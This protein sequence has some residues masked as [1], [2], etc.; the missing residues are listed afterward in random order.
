MTFCKLSKSYWLNDCYPPTLAAYPQFFSPPA[1]ILIAHNIMA[2][3]SGFS[4]CDALTTYVQ[5]NRSTPLCYTRDKIIDMPGVPLSNRHNEIFII[6]ESVITTL[7]FVLGKG[8]C[9]P[10]IQFPYSMAK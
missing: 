6:G 7:V 8:D 3:G 4:D 9:A 5:C 2:I 10:C 1:I